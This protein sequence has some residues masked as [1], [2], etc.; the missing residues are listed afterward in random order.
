MVA[1]VQRKLQYPAREVAEMLK[2]ENQI[3]S[4]AAGPEETTAV[5]TGTC[6]LTEMLALHAPPI[7][8]SE[9]FHDTLE[10]VTPELQLVLI[11]GESSSRPLMERVKDFCGKHAAK[12]AIYVSREYAMDGVDVEIRPIVAPYVLQV[13]LERMTEYL[14]ELR[15]KPL[16]EWTFSYIGRVP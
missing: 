4:V 3:Y 15:G 9:F 7:K 11:I 8:A 13:A 16:S 10:L 5:A 2:F 1:E 6:I 12:V 14:F